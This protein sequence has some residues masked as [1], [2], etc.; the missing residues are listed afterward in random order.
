MIPYAPHQ[1]GI[2]KLFLRSFLAWTFE[3]GLSFHCRIWKVATDSDRSASERLV[4]MRC[5]SAGDD[6]IDQGCFNA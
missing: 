1:H 4:A 6:Q 5:D 3:R 2:V